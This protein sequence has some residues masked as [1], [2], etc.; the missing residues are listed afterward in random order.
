MSTGNRRQIPASANPDVRNAVAL[1]WDEL[2]RING[3]GVKTS[4]EN[5]S[6]LQQVAS[7]ALAS[8]SGGGAVASSPLQSRQTNVSVA[9]PISPLSTFNAD[10][11][12]SKSCEIQ[13]IETDYP[14][15]VVM[16]NT[17]A[18]RAADSSRLSTVDPTPGT[19]VMVEVITTT[20]KLSIPMSPVPIFV[21]GDSTP[22]DV[23]YLKVVNT[24][25]ANTRSITI[26]ITYI[27]GEA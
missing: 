3:S 12:I 21:N 13:K 27:R 25:N 20:T 23:A 16:Y 6:T 19:G 10:I 14:A 18:A 9:G 5:R 15:Y 7:V 17:S 2:E 22:A 4:T 24:D 11:A 1:I 8:G 26:T